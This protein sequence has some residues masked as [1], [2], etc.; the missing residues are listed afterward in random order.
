MAKNAIKVAMD[1]SGKLM[2]QANGHPAKVVSYAAAAAIAFVG[3]SIGYGG[4]QG[5]K[6]L[7]DRNKA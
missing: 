4:Y 1:I 7:V 2:V 3:V 6:Y 5:V